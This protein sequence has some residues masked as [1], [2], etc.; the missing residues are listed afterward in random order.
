MELDERAMP[1]TSAASGIG[2]TI[3]FQRQME[4]EDLTPP[5]PPS[6]IN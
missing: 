1:V 4:L 3:A 6:G 5:S 2:R